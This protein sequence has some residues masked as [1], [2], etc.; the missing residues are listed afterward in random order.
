MPQTI[1]TV[2]G[3][4]SIPTN[5]SATLYTQSG[6]LATRVILNF[7][8]WFTTP[9]Y[10]AAN[11]SLTHVSAGGGSALIGFQHSVYTGINRSS[12]LMP[13]N[14]AAP[15]ATNAMTNVG[16]NQPSQGWLVSSHPSYMGS[17]NGNNISPRFVSP[18]LNSYNY[19]PTNYWIG[20]SDSIVVW[21]F[22]G[23]GP[24][25][26]LAYSFTTITET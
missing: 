19:M 5:G 24:N 13:T 1:A 22:T 4:T 16:S 18:T 25:A 9:D 11:L 14:A 21:W 15:A 26:T 3:T 8:S 12:Q 23:E 10:G 20:P 7:V 6:G 2:R 17:S